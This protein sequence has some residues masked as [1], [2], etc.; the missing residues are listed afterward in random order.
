MLR[1]PLVLCAIAGVLSLAA[2]PVPGAESAGV[3]HVVDR[4]KVGG[5]GGWDYLV[6]DADARRVYVSRSDRVL[7][8]DADSGKTIGE[9]ANTSGVHGIA[10]A[11][12]L[13]RG[14]TSNGRA[15]SVTVFDLKT[16]KTLAEIK[17]S[18]KNPDAILFDPATRHV[19]TFN[20]RSANA[21]VIDT[22][23]DREIGTIA[24]DGKPEFAATDGK[25]HVY[26]NIENKNELTAIDA[27]AQKVLATW[28][29]TGCEE[30]SGLAFDAAHQRLFSACGNARMIVT[31]SH[32]G[33]QVANLAIGKDVDAAAFDAQRHLV[34]ASNG[35]GTLTVI[36]QDDADHYRVA[37]NVATQ[38]SAR[39]LALDTKTHRLFLSAAEFGPAPAATPEHPHP[40]PPVI[41][42]SFTILVAGQ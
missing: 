6:A 28:P 20:G 42:G 30:P 16:L 4:W 27:R 21:S 19:F 1:F 7:V 41:E 11:P 23:T 37:E 10:L 15:D 32:N 36:H 9:I 14:Y 5:T 2:M 39:T 22:A 17:V 29:L 13:N 33:K 18:G 34:F 31:D 38:K 8:L 12:G 26:V 3:Y 25:G 35:E 24:L 40:R